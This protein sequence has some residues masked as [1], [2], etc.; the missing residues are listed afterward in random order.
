ML[1]IL[2]GNVGIYGGNSG[3]CEFIYIIIIEC[4]LVLENFVK[5][6]I[7]CF[8]WMDVIVCGLEMIV[9]CDGVCG[10]DKLDVL[11][12]FLWNYVGNILINQYLDINKIYEIFQDEVKC[13]MI[14]VIDNFMIFFVKY[15]D[16]LLLDFM[17]V[18][19]EDIIFNDYVGNMGYLIFI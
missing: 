12:K 19:Q 2:I 3:V 16:I 1:L 15:V 14:V 17:I 6:V 9:L 10:K 18:E 13:E 4:L 11:I 7:F 8:S 5:I